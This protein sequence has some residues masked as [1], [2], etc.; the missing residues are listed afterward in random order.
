VWTTKILV[1]G[2]NYTYSEDKIKQK[3]KQKET[4]FTLK[5]KLKTAKLHKKADTKVKERQCIN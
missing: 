2:H 1:Q 3:K 5:Q 4:Q